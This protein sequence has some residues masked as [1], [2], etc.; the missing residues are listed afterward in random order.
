MSSAE[1]TLLRMKPFNRLPNC[2]T[3]SSVCGFCVN[4]CFFC[5]NCFNCFQCGRRIWKENILNE[6]F[7]LIHKPYEK[8]IQ[9]LV[10]KSAVQQI[11]FLYFCP[12]CYACFAKTNT[13]HEVKPLANNSVLNYCIPRSP[14]KINVKCTKLKTFTYQPTPKFRM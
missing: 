6:K 8:P 12:C 4:E 7:K 14:M 3:T 5:K 2:F 9:L 1:S 10:W 13:Q 11:L